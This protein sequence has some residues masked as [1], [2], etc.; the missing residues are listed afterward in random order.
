MGSEEAIYQI[1]NYDPDPVFIH[2]HD[3]ND[4]DW[5]ALAN[6]NCIMKWPVYFRSEQTIEQRFGFDC[7]NIDNLKT[8]NLFAKFRKL[9][10]PY[11]PPVRYDFLTKKIQWKRTWFEI[12]NRYNAHE[13]ND[14]TYCVPADVPKY[15]YE[16]TLQDILSSSIFDQLETIVS[17]SQCGDYNFSYVRDFHQHYINAQS[18]LAWLDGIQQLRQTGKLT[19]YLKTNPMAQALT[20]EEILPVLSLSDTVWQHLSTEACVDLYNSTKVIK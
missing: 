20:I 11:N 13:V 18:S 10:F 2:I 5:R 15:V 4:T 19:E 16:I 14:E 8:R 3:N 7:F 12:R 6:I 17:Q 1:S 9:F